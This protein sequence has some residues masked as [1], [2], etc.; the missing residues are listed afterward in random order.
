MLCWKGFNDLVVRRFDPL[1]FAP[2]SEDEFITLQTKEI[3]NGRLAMISVA[4]Y[5]A[6]ELVNKKGIIENLL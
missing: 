4:G 1:G 2:K 3:N 5:V 6:Q